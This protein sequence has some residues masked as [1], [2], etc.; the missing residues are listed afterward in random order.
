MFEPQEIFSTRKLVMSSKKETTYGTPLLDASLTQTVRFNPG[1]FIDVAKDYYS[2]SGEGG[3]GP[4][5][6]DR[7]TRR[8]R[9]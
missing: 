7:S 5:L 1:D 2:D 3:Q 6:G 4:Q 9:R 8:S